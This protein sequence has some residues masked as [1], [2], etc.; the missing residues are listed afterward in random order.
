[1]TDETPQAGTQHRTDPRGL[2]AAF[3][4]CTCAALL[5]IWTVDHLPMVD[6]PQ[7]MAQLDHWKK[8]ADPDWRWRDL[9]TVRLLTPYLASYA[10]ARLFSVFLSIE[11]SFRVVLSLVVIAFP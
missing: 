3:A 2:G 6:L 7:H 11:D 8:M 4:L 1:M 9:F 5:P 10:L